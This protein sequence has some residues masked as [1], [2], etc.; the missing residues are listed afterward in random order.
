MKTIF[1]KRIKLLFPFYL[2]ILFLLFSINSFAQII[3]ED[4]ITNG[5]N[6]EKA[7]F[8]LWVKKDIKTIR[9][10][11]VLVPGSNHD[12]R[13]MVNDTTWQNLAMRHNFALLGCYYKDRI[14]DNMAIEEYVDAEKGS[15]QALLDIIQKFSKT[16]RHPELEF[17][18]LAL[19]GESAGG[20]FNYEFTCWNPQR[21]IAFV[22]NKGG[23]Y[24][25][26]LASNATW[27]V[28]GVFFIGSKDSPYRNNIVKG[29]FSINRRFGAKWI[30][31]EEIGVS[32][33]FEKSKEFVRFY[34]DHIIPLR[35]S[36]DK[37]NSSYTLRK[38]TSKGYI[39]ISPTGQIL[40]DLD[41]HQSEITSWF[42]NQKIAKKWLDFI[43]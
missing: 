38:L 11:I 1:D 30:L 41:H 40:P 7:A 25:S 43:K 35:V 24:Y 20:E 6:F 17:A 26:S 33:E 36:N 15:G 2:L 21:V 42:P 31:I 22:V 14:H 39:G 5:G 34:F 19:W 32:H 29:I 3:I 23:V 28:P 16:S 9:G 18:P 27:E 10:I 37:I 4:S 8:R 13:Y 12:G